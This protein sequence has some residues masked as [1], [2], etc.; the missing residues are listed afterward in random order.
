M[1]EK[2][3]ELEQLLD[4]INKAIENHLY[5]N[6]ISIEELDRTL[7]DWEVE[8]FSKKGTDSFRKYVMDKNSDE[9]NN[10]FYENNIPKIK[11]L[12]SEAL[13][14]YNNISS[15]NKNGINTPKLGSSL[16]VP[17]Q[18]FLKLLKS[19]LIKSGQEIF[20]IFKKKRVVGH[21]TES[22]F[23][24]LSVGEKKIQC[25]DFRYATLRAWDKVSDNDGWGNFSAI[26][27]KTKRQES[28]KTF[29]KR[30]K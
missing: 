5:I 20:G 27:E 10:E 26:D 15:V 13:K 4:D 8:G 18:D 23:F 30:L 1:K 9:S 17:D 22:G 2:V 21:L 25:P 11:L 28:L 19:G 7:L 12:L 6:T 14:N 29:R 24:E 16:K 3:N